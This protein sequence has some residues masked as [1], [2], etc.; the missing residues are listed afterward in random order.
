MTNH[1]TYLCHYLRYLTERKREREDEKRKQEGGR[2][3]WLGSVFP[4]ARN[5]YI[6]NYL[7]KNYLLAL[8]SH[9]LCPLSGILYSMISVAYSIQFLLCSHPHNPFSNSSIPIIKTP[10]NLRS[11]WIPI[12]Y[13]SNLLAII[14]CTICLSS[15]FLSRSKLKLK[16]RTRKGEKTNPVARY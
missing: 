5:K 4:T 11:F 16:M 6:C 2:K 3:R 1:N 10:P 14:L 7:I 13:L 8:N 15:L 9:M 12:L